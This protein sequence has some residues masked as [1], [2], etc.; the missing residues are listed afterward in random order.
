MNQL[1]DLLKNQLDDRMIDQLSEQLGGADKEQ[2]AIAANGAL[3]SMLTGLTKNADQGGA[4]SLLNMLDRDGDGS[5]F[6]DFQDILGGNK[7]PANPNAL[8]GG[9][10]LE[11][12]FGGKQGNMADMIS[13]MSGLNSSQSGS[14]M[15]MLAPMLM[16][17][18]TKVKSQQN[19]D[20]SGLSQIL[21]GTVDAQRQQSPLGGKEV[22]AF[23]RMLDQDGDGDIMD[24]LQNMGKGLL[25][26]FF[27]RR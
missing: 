21:K 27:G 9:S 3:S 26:S 11:Q 6:D 14:L 16:G 1:F 19:L 15:Q 22:D 18:L 17:A 7:R 5:V 24:D 13:R 4:S 23:S 25:G 10:M 8:N 20:E 2:T 12:I